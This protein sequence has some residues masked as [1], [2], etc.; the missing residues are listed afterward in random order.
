SPQ[1][2]ASPFD[3]ARTYFREDPSR[4]DRAG[5]P[6]DAYIEARA[7]AAAHHLLSDYD[8]V[9]FSYKEAGGVFQRVPAREWS[10]FLSGRLALDAAGNVIRA[11]R[12]DNKSAV[13]QRDAQPLYGPHPLVLRE[14]DPDLVLP[15]KVGVLAQKNG[16]TPS[17]FP[18]GNNP[19]VTVLGANEY[20]PKQP[21]REWDAE[22]VEQ[23]K[24]ADPIV[25]S[26]G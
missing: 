6:Y 12:R 15:D 23:F 2:T 22:W 9:L 1:S 19:F 20:E 21:V 11:V 18:P 17:P 14:A 5:K 24:A 13:N 8:G 26:E 25:R 10:N 4:P 16:R 3:I 7:E